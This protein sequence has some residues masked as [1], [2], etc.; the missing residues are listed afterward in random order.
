MGYGAMRYGGKPMVAVHRLIYQLANGAVP[1]DI[2]VLHKCDV[3]RCCNPAHLYLGNDADNM[4]DKV[5]K[6]RQTK[7]ESTKRNKLTEAQAKEI[8]GLKGT[9]SSPKLASRYGV[10]PGAISAIWRGDAWAYLR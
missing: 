8:L 7:G 10:K 2:W 1:D 6:G 5:A 9:I 3:P 4:R